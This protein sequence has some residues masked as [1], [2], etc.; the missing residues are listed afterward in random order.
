MV[1]PKSVRLALQVLRGKD[2]VAESRLV[3]CG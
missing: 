1:K 2:W 3:E